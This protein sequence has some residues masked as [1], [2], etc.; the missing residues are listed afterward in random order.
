VAAANTQI[1]ALAAAEGVILVDLYPA[2][3]GSTDTLIGPDGLHPS[4]AGYQ[5]MADTF[6][7]AVTQRL[8]Q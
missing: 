8:E 7:A 4:E 1:R 2:F 3:A 5:K 6:Y